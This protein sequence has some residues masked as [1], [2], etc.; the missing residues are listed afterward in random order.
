MTAPGAFLPAQDRWGRFSSLGRSLPEGA[1]V[2]VDRRVARLHP[3]LLR[4]LRARK[5]LAVVALAAGERTKSLAQV[6]RV[7]EAGARLPRTGTLACIG[8]GTLGDLC[9][10][11][12]HLLKRGVRL[13]HVPTTLLAAVDSSLGGKGAVH[14]GRVKNA[15]GVFHYAHETWLCPEVFRTLSPAQLREGQI[16]AWKMAVCLD[17][18]AYAAWQRRLPAMKPLVERARAMKAAVCAEDPYERTG[19]RRVLNFGHTL[20]HALE[21]LTGFRLTHGDAVGVGMLCALDV[22]RALGVTP[23]GLAQEVESTLT[24]RVLH[25]GRAALARALGGKSDAQVLQLL[26]SDKK[27]DRAG[28]PVMVLLHAVGDARAQE[29]PVEGLRRCLGAWRRGTLPG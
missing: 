17:Q 16:E 9:T 12:A 27:V 26:L 2:V 25:H 7:L 3:H 14:A 29:V 22:G 15:A 18:A 19:R 21:S 6:E 5:P 1:L 8:G 28:A 24:R 10:V 23:P 20:G 11:A 4:A 13:V